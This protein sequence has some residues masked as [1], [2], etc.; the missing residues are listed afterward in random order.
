MRDKLR[1]L[2]VEDELAIQTG[3]VDVLVF[4][5]YDVEATDDGKHGLELA[6]SGAFDLILLDVMLPSMIL[7]KRNTRFASLDAIR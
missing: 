7:S 4:H 3:L 2:V 5:G 6:Q 1:I